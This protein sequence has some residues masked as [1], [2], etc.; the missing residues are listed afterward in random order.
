MYFFF[1]SPTPDD[2]VFMA[3]ASLYATK[4]RNMIGA[5]CKPNKDF[6]GGITNGAEWYEAEGVMQDF[7][8]HFSN[9]VELTLELS[10]CKHPPASQLPRE[11][12]HNRE[13]LLS[14]LEAAQAGVRGVVT[15]RGRALG[16]A[17]VEVAGI[18]KHVQTTERG[19][20]WRLL[21]PGSYRCLGIQLYILLLVSSSQN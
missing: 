18:E 6:P 10:C 15:S 20:Y 2:D 16:G 21:A 5:V 14:Y 7:N 19:E 4:H 9:C 17:T 3:L 11:W 8:Y 1:K 12:E 13:A